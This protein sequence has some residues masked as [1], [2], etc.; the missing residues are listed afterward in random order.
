MQQSWRQDSDKLTFIVCQPLSR[1]I[2]GDDDNGVR[3]D[4]DA[5]DKMLGDINLFLQIEEEEDE[6]EVNGETPKSS[7]AAT[8][9]IIGEVELMI[10]EKKH[11]RKGFGR[12][13]LLSFF[14]YVS[15]HE[16]E[17][18]SEFASGD[19]VEATNLAAGDRSGLAFSCLTAKIGHANS[20]SLAL[21]RS[22]GFQLVTDEPNYF[23]EFELRKTDLRPEAAGEALKGNGIT[24]YAE[25][26]YR[27]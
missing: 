9:R 18:L 2:N 27:R 21:F 5:S 25:L 6:E 19:S 26:A 17:I 24:R 20:K 10:A 15:D 22:V 8:P 13:A 4:D 23:G 12:A 16:D 1:T 7:A 14:K 3:E 11:H